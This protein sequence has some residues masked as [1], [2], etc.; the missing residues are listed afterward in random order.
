M[1]CINK[2]LLKAL[3]EDLTKNGFYASF[4]IAKDVFTGDCT[5]AIDTS[6]RNIEDFLPIWIS[7]WHPG[8][9]CNQRRLLAS[10]PTSLGKHFLRAEVVLK[11]YP[12]NYE[13]VPIFDAKSAK[14]MLDF[15]GVFCQGI[16]FLSHSLKRI[17]FFKAI[18]KDGHVFLTSKDL[19]DQLHYSGS[20]NV[21][22]S[23]AFT[24]YNSKIVNRGK[25]DSAIEIEGI[26]SSLDNYFAFHELLRKAEIEA[27]IA[28]LKSANAEERREIEGLEANIAE[29]NVEIKNLEDCLPSLVEQV[30]CARV[31]FDLLNV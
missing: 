22:P 31:D 25:C 18:E 2:E 4:T 17:Q 29:R 5:S 24:K 26:H 20:Y 7:K 13:F 1:K 14:S 27:E 23:T 3:A 8:E 28:D 11:A 15:H 10:T 6:L 12:G 16:T 19:G 9:K 30:N 21:A